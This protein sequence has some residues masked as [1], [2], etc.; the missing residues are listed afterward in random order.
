M[1]INIS[2]NYL[3]GLVKS[4]KYLV[5]LRYVGVLRLFFIGFHFF[6]PVVEKCVQQLR[7]FRLIGLFQQLGLRVT[8]ARDSQGGK[9]Q[10]DDQGKSEMPHIHY[11][12]SVTEKLKCKNTKI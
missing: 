7:G 6:R 3:L 8:L 1:T 12:I 9:H 11:I 10:K 5:R 4:G 2:G